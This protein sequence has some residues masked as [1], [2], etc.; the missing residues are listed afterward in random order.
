MY[1]EFSKMWGQDGNRWNYC[2]GDWNFSTMTEFMEYYGITEASP[3]GKEEYYEGEKPIPCTQY[4]GFATNHR[5]RLIKHWHVD[6]CKP[7]MNIYSFKPTNLIT[8][9][10]SN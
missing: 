10:K 9:C 3:I 4:V 2:G 7:T 6:Y 8:P 1:I 5:D